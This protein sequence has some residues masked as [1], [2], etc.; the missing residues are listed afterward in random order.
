MAAVSRLFHC[1]PELAL[2]RL[3][4]LVYC[5]GPVAFYL[6]SCR[7][8]RRPGASFAAALAWALSSPI[9]LLLPDHGFEVPALWSARR[10]YLAFN[11]DDLP[12]LTSLLLLP[13]AVWFLARALK[14]SRL[15]DY[16]VA[17]IAMAGMM[18]ANVFGV[19]LAVF[20][21]LTVSLALDR[22]F[23]LSLLL[24]SALAVMGAY[25]VAS[26]WL[27]PSLLLTI[28]ANNEV[29]LSS[30]SAIAFGIV[31]LCFGI[32]WRLSAAY[33]WPARWMMLFGCVVILIPALGQYG[34]YFLAQ[35]GRYKI[36]AELAVVWIVVFAVH[37]L[38]ERAPKRIQFALLFPLLL[39]AGD[40]VISTRRFAEGL[41]H[42]F[43]AQQSIEY[44]SAKWVEANFPA[45]RVMMAGSLGN[46]L[47]T[48]T[49]VQQLSAQPYT[50]ARNWGERIAVY[51]IY[52]GENAGDR[53]GE[54]ALLW[55]KAFGVQ[56][57]GVSGPR[58]PE[59]WKP[60]LRPQ[61]FDGMLPALWR[62][63][64]T[65]IYRVPQRSAS[66][67]HVLRPEQLVRRRPING[68]D[69]AELFGFVAALD[70]ETS[71][72]ELEWRDSN[73]AKIRARV[74]TGEIVSTQINYHPGWQAFV[75]GGRRKVRPDGIGLM[76]VEPNC[77]GECEI[78]LRY[79]GGWE[80][81]LCRVASGGLLLLVLGAAAMR[82]FRYRATQLASCPHI[83]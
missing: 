24:R 61:K 2:N 68:L 80:S 70:S 64:D 29:A 12:H 47:N 53:D 6:L 62:E 20:V 75:N 39:L 63:E 38:L 79:D 17:G 74:A 22:R 33:E 50:T 25:V 15:F 46:F 52:V 18:L 49:Q 32:V 8:S 58:S 65:T 9:A 71:P 42:R 73:H 23:R 11:W 26:P 45:Q 10:L 54:Y 43:D 16:A 81:R 83:R 72:A 31:A 21:A 1:S 4:A 19:V 78:T 76:V 55:L 27:P 5:V 57:V 77:A 36:E 56:A 28:R 67:A 48:F 82:I 37:S 14:S 40:Q 51:T 59:Y 3:T 44:R 66:L 60:F 30:H 69:T 41:I 13:L 7:L 35:P 34:L